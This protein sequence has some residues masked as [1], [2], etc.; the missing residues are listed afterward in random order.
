MECSGNAEAGDG[1]ATSY[2]M[3]NTLENLGK[4]IIQQYANKDK[5][6]SIA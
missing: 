1:R 2:G 6:S 4:N 5:N 3:F